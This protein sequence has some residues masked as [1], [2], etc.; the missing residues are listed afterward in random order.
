M[1]ITYKI[2]MISLLLISFI[3]CEK[4][5][6]TPEFSVTTK[7]DADNPNKITFSI[8]GDAETFAIYTGDAGHEYEKSHL[9]L[10]DGKDVDLEERILTEEG[11]ALMEPVIIAHIESHNASNPDQVDVDFVLNGIQALVGITFTNTLTAKYEM[12]KLMD[13]MMPNNNILDELASYFDDNSTLLA[14]DGGFSTG[15]A[16]DRY[17]REYTYTYP[18]AGTYKA[19]VIA[20]NVSTKKYSG[21]GYQDNATASASEYN[22][23]RE[24]KEVAVTIQ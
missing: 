3:S 12:A 6:W 7:V 24:I 1:K 9:V 18:E 4:D 21:S 10:T 16:I 22:Y 17:D 13:A 8:T 14:P 15:A 5:D 2:V 23:Y 19:V 20:T 11:Y